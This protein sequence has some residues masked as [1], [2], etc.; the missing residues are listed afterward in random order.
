MKETDIQKLLTKTFSIPDTSDW[1]KIATSEIEGKDPFQELKWKDDDEIEYLPYYD[2]V[3]QQT[4]VPEFH[5]TPVNKDFLGNR[6]WFNMPVVQVVDANVANQKALEHLQ[7]GAD[8]ILFNIESN[9][10]FDIQKLLNEIQLPYCLIS[11]SG[12]IST[13]FINNLSNYISNHAHSKSFRGNLF[14]LNTQENS[15]LL[16]GAD[17]NHLGCF[18][19]SSTPVN[20]ICDAL[21]QGVAYLEKYTSKAIEHISFSIPTHTNF[22]IQISKLRALRMLWYQVANIYNLTN[23]NF[24]ALH[25]HARIEAWANEKLS[26][27]EN[28]LH[29]TTSAMASIIGGCD[30]L[31]VYAQDKNNIMME[32]IARNVSNILREESH[33]DKVEDPLAG[34]YVIES[35]TNQIAEKAWELFKTKSN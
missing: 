28:M 23:Y 16:N 20:E 27:H 22:L 19:N 33:F 6:T 13:R 2:S 21:L 30:S 25:I 29:A 12:N 10:S 32:R 14:W 34:S 24:N 31:S 26:P 35:M 5:R 15:L 4:E 3:L 11:F 9:D 7:N 1:K 17:F 18:V 8:G